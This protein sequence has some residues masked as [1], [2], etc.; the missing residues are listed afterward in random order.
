MTFAIKAMADPNVPRHIAENLRL[1]AA[2]RAKRPTTATW[3]YQIAHAFLNHA[4]AH[5]WLSV[6][7]RR[8]KGLASMGSG[9]L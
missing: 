5:G 8:R 3:L 9:L 4:E 6:N 7:V 1:I 2:H